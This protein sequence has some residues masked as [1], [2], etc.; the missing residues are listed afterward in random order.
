MPETYRVTRVTEVAEFDDRGRVHPMMRVEFYVGSHGP[1]TEK[2]S[3]DQF[4]ENAV[5]AKLGDFVRR[6]SVVTGE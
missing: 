3:K 5:R 2:F 4:D 6:L 1:F